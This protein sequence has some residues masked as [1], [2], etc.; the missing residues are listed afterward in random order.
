MKNIAD[1]VLARLKN[2]S[3]EEGR[4]H[5]LVLEDFAT[6]RLIARLSASNHRDRFI[7]KGAQLFK[8]WATSPHRPTRDADFF[9]FGASSPEELKL[10]FEE[11][12]AIETDPPD[13]IV[14]N[15]DSAAQIREDNLY[16]GVRIKLTAKVGKV[17][18]PAQVDVGFGDSITPKAKTVD[19]P[20]PL[21]F[22]SVRLHAYCSETSIAEKLHAAVIL[23]NANSRM[24]DFFDIFWL[25]NHQEFDSSRLR[26]AIYA[27]FE[28]RDTEVPT[29]TPRAYTKQF[30]ESAEKQIQWEGFLRKSRLESLDFVLTTERISQF[31]SPILDGSVAEATWQPESGWTEKSS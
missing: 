25:S 14:W 18:I 12:C 3:R 27:T 10:I 29:H 2:V 15:V 9:S 13:A 16:G 20:M 26:E 28:R 23:D 31:L 17:R 4:V 8:L 22:P 24:K 7:L 19:W 11:I 6:A 21:D 30:A 1:S 5:N